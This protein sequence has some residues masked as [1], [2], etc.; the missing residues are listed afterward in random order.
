MGYSVIINFICLLILFILYVWVMMDVMIEQERK[1]K[2]NINIFIT[3]LA[4]ISEIIC[5]FVDNSCVEYRYL[6]IIFNVIGFTVTPYILVIESNFFSRFYHKRNLLCYIPA[7][8]NAFLVI[9]SP[10]TG[11]I[12]FVS[13]NNEYIRGEFFYIYV[14]HYITMIC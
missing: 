4:V 5:C 1:R 8:I 6:S 12:F 14:N 2:M 9:L 7:L 10:F 13:K 3:M 11:W